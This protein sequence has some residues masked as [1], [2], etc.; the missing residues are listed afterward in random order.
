MFPADP[1]S[2][3]C[4][5]SKVPLSLIG[6]LKDK[7]VMVGAVGVTADHVETPEEVSR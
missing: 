4:A 5:G 6:L 2:L 7:Q 3:E 1:V